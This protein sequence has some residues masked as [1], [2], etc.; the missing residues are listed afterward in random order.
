MEVNRERV[1]QMDV[2]KLSE[3]S[4]R[5]EIY[6]ATQ[7]WYLVMLFCLLGS[8]LGW[9]VVQAWPSPHRVSKELFVGL[10]V[11]QAGDDRSA[12]EHSGLPL[13]NANDYKNWQMASL[14]TIIYTQP[15]LDDTLQRLR[16]QDP[17]W[18]SVE[19]EE[20]AGMLHAY[21]RNA[22][23]WRLVAEHTNPMYATEAVIL[24]QDAIVAQVHASVAAAQEALQYDLQM[25]ATAGAQTGAADR[26]AL[27]TETQG[28]LEEL[29]VGL[30]NRKANEAPDEPLRMQVWQA[31]APVVESESGQLLEE[32]YPA[33]GEPASAYVDWI[34]Q[35]Q[36]VLDGELAGAH[37]QFQTH[38]QRYEV[39]AEQYAQAARDSLGLSAELLVQKISDRRLD[40]EQVRPTGQA[41]L[42]GAALG[43][44]VW[45]LGWLVRPALRAAR[46]AQSQTGE[47]TR[48]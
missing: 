19:G 18:N 7:R 5:E 44:I 33:L 22:G 42:V 28:R 36:P 3:W 15:V 24:W 2:I 29:R 17:Y 9:A 37:W 40:A 25:Q 8:L 12:R 13:T 11:Y 38:S 27:L 41:M 6:A 35:V 45:F 34:E 26:V 47:P 1:P 16:N 30:T 43:L 46:S 14:N 48:V 10:N 31:A 4:V 32:S 20:L 39:L 23:K 21:W